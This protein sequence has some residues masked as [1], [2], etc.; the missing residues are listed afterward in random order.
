MNKG[1]FLHTKATGYEG[2]GIAVNS[3]AP[4]RPLHGHRRNDAWSI[5][6]PKDRQQ[7]RALSLQVVAQDTT[8]FPSSYSI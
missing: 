6:S 4:R 2:V 1:H 7:D 5:V 8:C 3:D